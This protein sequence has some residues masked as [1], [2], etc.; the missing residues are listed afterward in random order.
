MTSNEAFQNLEAAEKR[1]SQ[2]YNDY[3]EHYSQMARDAVRWS[4]ITF[5]ALW[6]IAVLLILLGVV[7]L[8]NQAYLW[9]FILTA[10]GAGLIW[11]IWNHARDS[12]DRL[13]REQTALLSELNHHTET[14]FR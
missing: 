13:K 2:S 3:C 11:L 1:V 6:G 10:A 9:W 5:I 4:T 12:K 14:F 7:M 8:F